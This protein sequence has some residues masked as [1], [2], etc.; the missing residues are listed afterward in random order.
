MQNAKQGTQNTE[1]V[2]E[3]AL[4]IIAV[5]FCKTDFKNGV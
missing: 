4:K 2:L 5:T 1:R 3:S